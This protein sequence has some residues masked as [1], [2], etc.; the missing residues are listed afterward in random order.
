MCQPAPPQLKNCVCLTLLCRLPIFLRFFG[1]NTLVKIVTIHQVWVLL[2]I[3]AAPSAEQKEKIPG[4][5]GIRGT[6]AQLPVKDYLF[7]FE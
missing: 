4:A 2:A 1:S 7:N 5:P 3:W 6:R